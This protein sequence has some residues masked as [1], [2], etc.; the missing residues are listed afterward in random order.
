MGEGIEDGNLRGFSNWIA[1]T[2]ILLQKIVDHHATMFK[3]VKFATT[4]GKPKGRKGWQAINGMKEEM[5]IMSNRLNQAWKVVYQFAGLLD[6]RKDPEF[7]IVNNSHDDK[8]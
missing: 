7:E 4:N 5:R 2:E 6:V 8:V 3:E 1:E